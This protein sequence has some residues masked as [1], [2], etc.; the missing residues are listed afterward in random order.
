MNLRRFKANLLQISVY[1]ILLSL[2]AIGSASAASSSGSVG[3]EGT[4]PGSPPT[5]A[6]TITFPKNGQVFTDSPI[7]VTGICPKGVL[8]KL[9]KNNIFGGSAQCSS[10]NFSIVTDLFS[11][12]NDLIARVYND[13]DQAGPDSNIVSVTFNNARPFAGSQITITSNFA[14]RGANPGE[15][16]SWPIIISGGTPPYAISVDWGDA[17]SPDLLS[18]TFAGT[19][20]PSHI[21]DAS[22][23]FRILIKATD[24]KGNTAFLQLVGV[25][26]G[27]LAQTS[28]AAK[29]PAVITR[30]RTLWWPAAILL[31]FIVAAFWLGRRHELYSLRKRLEREQIN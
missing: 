20:T 15:T 11:G 30:T 17:K 26:N 5:T 18:Q 9:F 13:L 2:L 14:K 24:S 16:L 27:P 29:G 8:V 10:G 4:V 25:A 19:F 28:T 22:G 6:A 7:T 1:T 23:V 3:V 12:T 21:Y 31:V